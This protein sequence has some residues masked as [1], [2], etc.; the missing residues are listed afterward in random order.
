MNG[1][2]RNCPLV[3]VSVAVT[4]ERGRLLLVQEEKPDCRGQWN[5]PGGHMDRGESIIAGAERELREETHVT[6]RMESLIAVFSGPTAIR[7]VFGAPLGHQTPRAGHEIL[8]VRMVAIDDLRKMSD[9]ELCSPHAL[10][11]VADR[12]QRGVRFPI[13]SFVHFA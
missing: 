10:R 8:D 11:D 4:D 6:L 9:A 3:H 5:L 12:L 13:E 1:P 7:F 2:V